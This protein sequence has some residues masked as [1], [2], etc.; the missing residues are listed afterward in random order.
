[1]LAR[2]RE[3][4]LVGLFLSSAAVSDVLRLWV[5]SLL[6]LIDLQ[7]AEHRTK[8]QGEKKNSGSADLRRKN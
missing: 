7:T 8:V 1:M 3:R 5:I 6:R 4:E 2:E